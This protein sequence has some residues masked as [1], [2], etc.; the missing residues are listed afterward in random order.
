VRLLLATQNPKKGKE[1]AALMQGAFDVVTLRDVGLQDIVIVEDAETF[2]GNAQKKVDAVMAAM[3]PSMAIDVI[4]GDDSG[5]C[6]DA[7]GGRPGV[8]SAR[9][10]ADAGVAKPNESS[11]DAN[12]RLLLIAMSAV[13]ME[14]RGAHFVCALH[15]LVVRSGDRCQAE[16]RVFGRIGLLRG[17]HAGFGYDPLFVLPSGKTMAELDAAQKHAISHRGQAVAALHAALQ[18]HLQK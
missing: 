14:Q 4:V 3:T 8:R 18:T 15:A 10:A 16:G 9:F 17:G 1:L 5:L 12:N 11:D 7:L 13:P 2:A 6:V